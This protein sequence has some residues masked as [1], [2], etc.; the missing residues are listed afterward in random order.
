[1]AWQSWPTA[2]TAGES[3]S[4]TRCRN[5]ATSSPRPAS[6]QSD[7]CERC[8]SAS[9]GCEI[10]Q[11][12]QLTQGARVP[13]DPG[14]PVRNGC[15]ERHLPGEDLKQHIE[16]RLDHGAARGMISLGDAGSFRP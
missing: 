5:G 10:E 3:E 15:V 1:M 12:R 7:Y 13:F 9:G 8:P 2:P 11:I 16:A 4:R 14:L 6:S